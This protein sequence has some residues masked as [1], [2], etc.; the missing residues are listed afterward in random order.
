MN[1]VVLMKR[2]KTSAPNS[3]TRKTLLVALIVALLAGSTLIP[4]VSAVPE[5]TVKLNFEKWFLKNDKLSNFPKWDSGAKAATREIAGA[6][7]WSTDSE[8]LTG[9]APFAVRFAAPT[10]GGTWDFGDLCYSGEQYHIHTYKHTGTYTATYTPA[11]G[12]P[13]TITIT[14]V[15]SLPK[16]QQR[17][18]IEFEPDKSVTSN[19]KSFFGLF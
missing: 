11:S 14:V 7:A 6:L 1:D 17:K 12:S 10:S 16:D 8:T 3:K 4:A 13:D 19:E 18:D 9:A 15:D 2:Q 5:D